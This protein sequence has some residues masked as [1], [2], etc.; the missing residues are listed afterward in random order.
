MAFGKK[1][2]Y[3]DDLISYAESVDMLLMDM[4][5]WGYKNLTKEKLNETLQS[6]FSI[7]F[8]IRKELDRI[9]D[10]KKIG[11]IE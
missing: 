1:E 3:T 7:G 10:I 5:N 2:T 11:L 4:R 8:A 6:D 9:F